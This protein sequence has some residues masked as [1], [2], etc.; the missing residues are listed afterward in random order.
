MVVAVGLG[1]LAVLIVTGIFGVAPL[2][3]RSTGVA[4]TENPATEAH[5]ATQAAVGA[6]GVQQLGLTLRYPSYE[7]KLLEAKVGVP[8]RL[9][10]E[11]IGEPG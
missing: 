7:P 3:G 11:A 1:G 2:G 4:W 9:S 6:D 5:Q 10:L 8:L